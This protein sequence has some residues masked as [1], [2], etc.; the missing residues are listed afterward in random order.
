ME[1]RDGNRVEALPYELL[2]GAPGLRPSAERGDEGL[3]EEPLALAPRTARPCTVTLCATMSGSASSAA[4][5]DTHLPNALR[6][7]RLLP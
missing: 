2:E 7:L 4:L 5:L 6:L 3:P 1:G